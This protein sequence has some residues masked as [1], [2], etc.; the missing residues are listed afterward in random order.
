M[1]TPLICVVGSINQDTTLRVP[2][3]PAGGDTVLAT[4]RSRSPG[5]KGA[6]QAAASAALGARVV[7]VGAVGDDDAGREALQS[8]HSRGVDVSCVVTCEGQATGAAVLLIADDGENLI[9]VDAGANSWLQEPDVEAA[10]ESRGPAVILGQLEIPVACL[11][12]AARAAAGTTTGAPLFVLNPAP[13]P[14]D[15]PGLDAVTGLLPLVDILVPNRG[16]LGRLA[17]R[18]TPSTPEEVRSCIEALDFDGAVV[19][20]LGSEGAVVWQSGELISV[21]AVPVDAVDTSGAGDVFCGVLAHRL[22]AGDP[23]VD[24]VRRA[25]GAAAVSTTLTGAQVPADFS[26]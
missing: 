3:L 10:V 14:A 15:R 17:G 5:G 19:V 26:G 21:P 20:T 1:T 18:P 7:M 16:E 8:L 22:A 12:A 4:G 9:V 6:N 11:K 2:A 23:L 24:C 25:N 13:M